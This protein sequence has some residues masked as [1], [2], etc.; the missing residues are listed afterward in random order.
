VQLKDGKKEVKHLVDIIGACIVL[1]SLLM[2]YNKDAVP[3]EWYNEISKIALSLYDEEEIYIANVEE[4]GTNGRT[5]ITFVEGSFFMNDPYFLNHQ[6]GK[7][8]EL[9]WSETLIQS[10][11]LF[12]TL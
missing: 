1:H 7:F 3:Q 12:R 4:E 5:T 9:E 8:K 11:I 2:N 10:R 6:F